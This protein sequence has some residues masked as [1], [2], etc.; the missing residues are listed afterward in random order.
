MRYI[1]EI[2]FEI[3]QTVWQANYNQRHYNYTCPTC[4][5]TGTLFNCSG[6]TVKCLGCYGS[7]T[8]GTTVQ[9]WHPVEKV[10]KELEVSFGEEGNYSVISVLF[11]TFGA[12]DGEGWEVE[13]RADNLEESFS[14]KDECTTY[15]ERKNEEYKNYGL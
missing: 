1:A 5:G 10:I 7:K 12:T 8:K 15:C 4:K 2:P 14:T 9:D 13:D 11:D 6:E 3:G